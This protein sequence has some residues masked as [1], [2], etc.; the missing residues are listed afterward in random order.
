ML[1][2]YIRIIFSVIFVNYIWFLIMYLNSMHVAQ[3][4][5]LLRDFHNFY[6]ILKKCFPS[7]GS[8][9]WHHGSMG[10]SITV[11]HMQ[12]VNP[13]ETGNFAEKFHNYLFMIHYLKSVMGRHFFK[14]FLVILKT[15]ASEL[16]EN[17]EEIYSMHSDNMFRILKSSTTY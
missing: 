3:G 7:T 15:F 1:H 6:K 17:L 5:L 8:E 9:Q 14:I 10:V 12:R 13:P 4:K 11:T 16:L 2:N